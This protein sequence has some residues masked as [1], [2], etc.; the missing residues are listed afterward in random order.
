V[1]VE[2]DV[3]LGVGLAEAVEV[4]RATAVMF[5]RKVVRQVTVLPPGLPVPLHWL[6][7]IGIARLIAEAVPTEQATVAPPPFAEPLHWVT[8]ALVVDAGNGLQ[9]TVPP[10]P[11]PEPT[12]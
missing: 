10:P 8:V 7:E 6:I 1:A 9:F 5:V 2:L 3:D 4:A 12:H 11:P